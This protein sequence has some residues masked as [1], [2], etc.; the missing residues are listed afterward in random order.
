MWLVYS[1]N[2]ED[3]WVARVPLPVQPEAGAFPSDEFEKAIPGGPV[4]GWNLYSPKWAPATVVDAGGKRRLE[5]SDA[6]PYDYARA[7]RVFPA[8]QAVRVELRIEAA[9][10]NARLEIDLCD[11][12]GRRPVRLALA[13][14]GTVRA[15]DGEAMAEAGRYAAGGETTLLVTTDPAAGGYAVRVNRGEPRRFA[16]AEKDVARVE[17][18]SL[19]TGPWRGCGE[20]S[21]VPAGS[22]VPVATPA[23]FCVAEPKIR[24]AP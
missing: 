8:A 24:P 23:V 12:A 9:Q 19:R 7:V 14:D 10:A 13:E 16:V 5:L 15:A 22:D 1:V 11:A 2:K 20:M 18:L 6:D 4:P 3:I 21:E 17:R